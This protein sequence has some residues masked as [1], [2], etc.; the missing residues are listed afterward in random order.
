M[1]SFPVM[2]AESEDMPRPAAR[3]R[4]GLQRSLE[5]RVVP[6]P[7]PL[8][9]L[10]VNL[11]VERSSCYRAGACDGCVKDI[12]VTDRDLKFKLWDR[13]NFKQVTSS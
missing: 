2:K 6:G 10:Q 12:R 13:D 3:C 9:K 1:M 7:P 11:S 8:G 5:A 4:S